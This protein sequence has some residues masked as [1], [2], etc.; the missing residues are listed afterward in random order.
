MTKTDVLQNLLDTAVAREALQ[1]STLNNGLQSAVDDPR[2]AFADAASKAADA[3]IQTRTRIAGL[4]AL[5]AEVA[6]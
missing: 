2:P 1:L 5:I 3:L 4:Q 6:P